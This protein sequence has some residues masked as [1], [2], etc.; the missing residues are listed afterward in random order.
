MLIIAFGI[1]LYH[2]VLPNFV[3]LFGVFLVIDGNLWK[4]LKANLKSKF[5][6]NMFVLQ[7]VFF[8][9]FIIGFFVSNDK[10]EALKHIGS[11]ALLLV[12]PFLFLITGSIFLK[13]KLFF[14]KMF[15]AGNILAS[16]TCYVLA[17][18]HSLHIIDGVLVFNSALEGARDYFN[19]IYFSVFQHPG[20]FSM[21]LVFSI[22]ILFYFNEKNII[23]NSGKRK[24]FFYFILAFFVITVVL[25]MSRAGILSLSILFVWQILQ[26]F[27]KYKSK[28]LKVSISIAFIISLVFVSQTNRVKNTFTQIGEIYSS[29]IEHKIKP[30]TRLILWETSIQ[31]IK[32]EVLFGYGTGDYKNIFVRNYSENEFAEKNHIGNNVH[33]Q[34]LEILLSSGVFAVII[35]LIIF[36]Y[37]AVYSL[38]R[39]NYLFFSLLLIISFN[40]LF[41]SMLNTLAGILFLSFFLNYFIFVFNDEVETIDNE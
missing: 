32:H 40:F 15:V 30:P 3:I 26:K 2:Y 12:F 4:Q 37:P 17:L 24:I 7:I 36:I 27:Y 11:K 33:N 6:R 25:L 1:P 39:R 14:L 35:L 10:D 20:Y 38:S 28:L 22:A 5:R 29:N 19:Y 9:I 23:F 34:F 18:Y 16:V 21:Y 31:L 41:E 8:A 13:N